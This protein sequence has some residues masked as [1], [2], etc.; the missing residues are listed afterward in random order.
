MIL[1]VIHTCVQ[2]QV[3][4]C[5]G[6]LRLCH[7]RPDVSDPHP[8]HLQVSNMIRKLKRGTLCADVTSPPVPPPR[9]VDLSVGPRVTPP[10]RRGSVVRQWLTVGGRDVG[11]GGRGPNSLRSTVVGHTRSRHSCRSQS[12]LVSPPPEGERPKDQVGEVGGY[13]FQSLDPGPENQQGRQKRN[14]CRRPWFFFSVHPERSDVLEPF[15]FPYN[16]TLLPLL[17]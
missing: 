3:V 8:A 1:T 9:E 10:R 5:V 17:W 4:F 14:R 16:R 15:P 13:Q 7:L 6:L 12:V 2:V 11:D